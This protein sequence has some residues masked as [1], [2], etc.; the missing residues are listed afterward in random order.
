MSALCSLKAESGVAPAGNSPG[1]RGRSVTRHASGSTAPLLS[2]LYGRNIILKVKLESG[3][4]HLSFRRSDQALSRINMGFTFVNLHHPTLSARCSAS[5]NPC[6]LIPP[7][8]PP[9]PPPRAPPCGVTPLRTAPAAVAATA[10]DRA[11]AAKPST[12]ADAKSPAPQG[13]DN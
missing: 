8:P 10:S 9:P 11:A 4:S 7:P 5:R 6:P 13:R 1:M 12:S 3:L 2:G